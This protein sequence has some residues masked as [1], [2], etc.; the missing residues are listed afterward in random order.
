MFLEQRLANPKQA[1][2]FSALFWI[3]WA[4]H[5][6]GSPP[7]P[8]PPPDYAAANRAGTIADAQTLSARRAIDNAAKFGGKAFQFGVITKQEETLKSGY[9][10]VDYQVQTGT[11]REKDKYGRIVDLP[12]YETRTKYTDSSG[13]E[14]AKADALT[15]G[16]AYYQLY[17]DKGERLAKPLKIS[18]QEAIADFTGLSDIDASKKLAEYQKD[19]GKATAQYLLDLQ[20]QFGTQY[21][22]QARDQLRA[23]DPTGFDLRENLAKESLG[24]QF[25]KIED[26]PDLKGL[27]NAPT[28]EMAGNGPALNRVGSGPSFGNLSSGSTL[29]R[30]GSGPQFGLQN[31][32]PQFAA[33]NEFEGGGAAALGRSEV[34]RQLGQALFNNGQLSPEEERRLNNS[35]RGAQTARGNVYGNAPVAQEILARYGAENEKARQARSDVVSYLSSGQSSYDISKAIRQ[36]ANTL[37]QQGYMN[38]STALGVNNNLAQK[39]FENQIAAVGQRNS[40][41]QAELENINKAISGDNQAMQQAYENYKSSVGANNAMSLTEY[42]NSINAVATRNQTRQQEYANQNAAIQYQNQMAQQGYQNLLNNINQN[43]QATQNRLSNMQTFAGL[44]PIVNQGNALQGLQQ[45]AAPFMQTPIPQGIGLNPNAGKV[46]TD[47]ALGVYDNQTRQYQSQMSYAQGTY[48]SPVSW[49]NAI[50][51]LF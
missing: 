4:K 6:G 27:G 8:P 48:T 28:L 22:T 13:R 18:E 7:S 42:Q 44:T 19:E 38:Y 25:K 24:T 20:K 16:T 49:L 14:V 46:G 32:G 50:G 39:E 43:N 36:E 47:F 45:Q 15:T 35:V 51:G 30:I 23:V 29:E 17:N 5:G 2:S 10:S 31:Y 41:S 37:A 40:A 1:H 34:E 12:V 21:A 33:G 11:T 26:L 3:S 9:K